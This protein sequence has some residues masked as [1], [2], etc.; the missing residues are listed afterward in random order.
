MKILTHKLLSIILIVFTVMMVMHSAKASTM[1]LSMSLAEIAGGNDSGCDMCPADN[2]GM[3][4]KCSFDC[5]VSIS[6]FLVSSVTA[7]RIPNSNVWDV[8][9]ISRF[10]NRKSPPDIQPPIL[11]S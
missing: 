4:M 8:M 11:I 5:T 2:D 9:P 6:G 3:P 1:N 10:E 7:L